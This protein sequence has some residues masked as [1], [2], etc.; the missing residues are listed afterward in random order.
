M[1]DENLALQWPM[2]RRNAPS[3]YSALRQ[4]KPGKEAGH[5]APGARIM[6]P[7]RPESAVEE[8]GI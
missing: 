4:Q 2:V 1:M 3:G 5:A 7:G 6:R 8:L